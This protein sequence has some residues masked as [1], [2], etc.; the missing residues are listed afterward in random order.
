MS[1]CS[2][3]TTCLRGDFNP[4]SPSKYKLYQI[5]RYKKPLNDDLKK[6]FGIKELGFRYLY[7]TANNVLLD[8]QRFIVQFQNK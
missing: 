6:Q 7:D 4:I 1:K 8:Y 3:T 2:S 5:L